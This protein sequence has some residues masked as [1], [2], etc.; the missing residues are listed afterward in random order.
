[1]SELY[2]SGADALPDAYT[3][4]SFKL[5]NRADPK[6]IAVFKIQ[7]YDAAHGL[8]Y[9]ITGIISDDDA[10]NSGEDIKVETTLAFGD[11][12]CF[13]VQ[14]P[15]DSIKIEVKNASPGDASS[16]RIFGNAR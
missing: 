4:T 11:S 10:T 16:C 14:L 1:M 12:Y 6:A 15:Y 5:R 2:D 13:A 9:K 3:P 8:K 7:N